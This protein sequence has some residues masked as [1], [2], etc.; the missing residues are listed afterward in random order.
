MSTYKPKLKKKK[1][2]L[3]FIS[4]IWNYITPKRA[5][6]SISKQMK[7][8]K[9]EKKKRR[10][11]KRNFLCSPNKLIVNKQLNF[12][13]VCILKKNL[14]TRATREVVLFLLFDPYFRFFIQFSHIF[15]FDPRAKTRGMRQW[16]FSHRG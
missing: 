8:A 6:L 13:F 12:Y 2:K 3:I 10:S 4:E 1:S 9:Y 15:C 16:S 14:Q 5:E 11:K 7:F